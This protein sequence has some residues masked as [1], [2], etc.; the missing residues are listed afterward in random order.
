LWSK[1]RADTEAF[2]TSSYINKR[3]AFC[4]ELA[5]MPI[6]AGNV[7]LLH[8]KQYNNYPCLRILEAFRCEYSIAEMRVVS[9]HSDTYIKLLHS[10]NRRLRTQIMHEPN[11]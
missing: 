1:G 9:E 8:N 4:R 5:E 3:K 2:T 11:N 6:D 10:T 7:Y